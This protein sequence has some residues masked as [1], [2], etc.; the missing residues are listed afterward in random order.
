[1]EKYLWLPV[2]KSANGPTWKNS[3]RRSWRPRYRICEHGA[4]VNGKSLIKISLSEKTLPPKELVSVTYVHRIF[5]IGVFHG[6]TYSWP[7]T[8]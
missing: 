8:W 7:M 2:E 6:V 1:V 4:K 5:V 3:F